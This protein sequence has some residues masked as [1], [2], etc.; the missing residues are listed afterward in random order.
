MNQIIKK[1]SLLLIIFLVIEA[2]LTLVLF[3]FCKEISYVPDRGYPLIESY[4][5][6]LSPVL[7]ILFSFVN[8]LVSFLLADFVV[9]KKPEFFSKLLLILII[10]ILGIGF[11]LFYFNKF[12]EFWSFIISV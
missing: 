10:I 12:L 8:V 7:F 5:C 11:Y 6:L 9:I 2:I 1:I 4:K 3:S